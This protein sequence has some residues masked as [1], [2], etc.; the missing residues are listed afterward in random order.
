[1]LKA[2]KKLLEDSRIVIAISLTILV[3]YLSLGQTGNIIQTVHV[4]DKSLHGFAYFGLSLSWMFAI[5]KSHSSFNWMVVIGFLLFLLGIL[6]E[7]L[8]GSITDYRTTDFFDVIANMFG[9]LIALISFRILLRLY[10]SF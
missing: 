3:I 8:Q 7:F 1:M 2:I 6:L 10:H 4:S 9:I 5:R